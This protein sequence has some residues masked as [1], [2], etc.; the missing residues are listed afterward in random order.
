MLNILLTIFL[1]V[2]LVY[3]GMYWFLKNPVL[4]ATVPAIGNTNADA[5]RLR[6][7][8]ER[9]AAGQPARAFHN[10]EQLNAVADYIEAEFTKSGCK[11]VRET[12]DVGGNDYH[13]IICS[14]GPRDGPRVII[15]AHY[16]VAGDNNPG[17][18]ET[19]PRWPRRNWPRKWGASWV[20]PNDRT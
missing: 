9:L 7:H 1:A 12:F 13:N 2:A 3:G 17:A 14:L 20:P 19:N 16:D 8:V 5:T 10:V 6:A 11:P 18:E 15:G 4:F